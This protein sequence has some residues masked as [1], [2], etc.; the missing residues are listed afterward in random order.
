MPHF[1]M[2]CSES[3]LKSHHEECIIEQIYH[4]ANSTGLFDEGDIKVKINPFQKC[5]VD[6]MRRFYP[7]FFSN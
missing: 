6:N 7:C 5:S 4:V 3:I 1:I 2:D